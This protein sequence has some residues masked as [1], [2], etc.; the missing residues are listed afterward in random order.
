MADP[1]S[2]EPDDIFAAV[3]ESAPD[4][5]VI[6]GQ[7]GRIRLVNAQLEALFGYPRQELMGQPIEMLLPAR[8]RAPHVTARQTYA[9]APRA[10]GLHRSVELYGSRKDGTEFPVEVSLSPLQTAAG[11]LVASAIRDLTGRKQLEAGVLEASR[12]KGAFLANMSHELRTPLNAIIGFAELMHSGKVG[13]MS[14]RHTEYLGDILISSRHLL[15]LINDV[16]DLAKIESG[17]MQFSFEPVDL[18][19]AA[20][21]VLDIVRGLA[22]NKRLAIERVVDPALGE[23]VVD[24]ARIRQVLYNYLSNAIKFTPDG[25]RVRLSIGA[26]GP[27]HFRIEVEDTGVGVP[28]DLIPH[29]FREFQQLDSTTGKRYQGTGLGLVLARRIAEGHGGSVSVRSAP[30]QGSTFSAVL[31]RTSPMRLR[32]EFR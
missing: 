13:P 9:A 11:L 23:V 15:R 12:L 31:P 7:D 24:P 25:G 4:A 32:R 14:E 3:F 16:L 6:T 29:L 30:G 20:D 2:K 8:F 1:E 18:T 27:D 21:E 26:A 22:D 17:Q 28:P 19:G 10:T 5:M